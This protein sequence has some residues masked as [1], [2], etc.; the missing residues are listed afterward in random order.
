M[1]SVTRKSMYFLCV[2]N[3]NTIRE[4]KKSIKN[5]SYNGFENYHI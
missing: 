2:E 5:K 4:E 1:N 3:V